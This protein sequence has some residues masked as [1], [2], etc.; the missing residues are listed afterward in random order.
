MVVN[1]ATGP[2]Q[3]TNIVD[4]IDLRSNKSLSCTI[5]NFPMPNVASFGGLVNNTIPMVCGGSLPSSNSC[6]F[7][8][9]GSWQQGMRLE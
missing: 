2:G 4:I 6:Y 9:K 7:F 5:P 8:M 3:A 1:G